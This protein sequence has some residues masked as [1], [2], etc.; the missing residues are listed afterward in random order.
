VWRKSK[1]LFAMPEEDRA[2]WIK[3]KLTVPQTETTKGIIRKNVDRGMIE[4]AVKE[5]DVLM[6]RLRALARGEKT[7]IALGEASER[8]RQATAEQGHTT[9]PLK[10]AIKSQHQSRPPGS[11]AAGKPPSSRARASAT[12]CCAS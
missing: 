2:N 9:V 10:G 5:S 6:I 11:D 1:R 8:N 3:S 12:S 4:K 7:G